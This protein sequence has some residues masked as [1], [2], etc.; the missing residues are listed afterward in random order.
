MAVT[1]KHHDGFC[2]FDSQLTDFTPRHAPF[3]RDIIGELA[4]EPNWEKYLEYYIG[5]VE[6][7]MREYRPAGVWFDGSHKTEAEWNGR[8]VYDLIKR[9]NPN[10]IVNDRGRFGDLFTPERSLPENLP[11]Y[12]FKACQSVSQQAWDYRQVSTHFSV[13]ELI[14]SLQKTADAGGNYLLNRGPKPDGAIDDT[15]RRIMTAIGDWLDTL[16][17]AAYDTHAVDTGDPVHADDPLG[18]AIRLTGRD[19]SLF[20]H[21]LSWPDV[22][23]IRV[24]AT[25][26]GKVVSVAA[27]GSTEPAGGA[28]DNADGGSDA[29]PTAAGAIEVRLPTT[30]WQAL[31]AVLRLDFDREVPQ[32]PSVQPPRPVTWPL[33]PGQALVLRP[34]DLARIGRGPKGKPVQLLAVPGYGECLSGWMDVAQS[35]VFPLDVDE[36]RDVELG[37]DFAAP[38]R[39]DD[40]VLA[41]EVDG[42]RRARIEIQGSYENEPES[43]ARGSMTVPSAGDFAELR[44]AL[45]GLVAGQHEIRLYPKRLHWGYFFGFLGR[46]RLRLRGAG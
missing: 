46:T 3:G 36:A 8:E 30:P 2:L 31:P 29:T 19:R 4:D 18:D 27:L 24:P 13:P 41:V 21:L 35:V 25:K 10:A 1:A 28:S 40:S 43:S 45:P 9:Y 12:L 16:G 15:Q 5:Q 22:D 7:P 17:Q 23:R 44:V 37:L 20:V 26:L 32:R 34:G 6:E 42:S 14:R 38:R 33:D 11:G 39:M